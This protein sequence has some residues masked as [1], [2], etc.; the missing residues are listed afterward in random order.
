MS[1]DYLF[2][3]IPMYVEMFY[4]NSIKHLLHF[5]EQFGQLEVCLPCSRLLTGIPILA[6]FWYSFWNSSLH[7]CINSV[8]CQHIVSIKKTLKISKCRSSKQTLTF[9]A[10]YN[11]TNLLI[12]ILWMYKSQFCEI[13]DQVQE[14]HII[15]PTFRVIYVVKL[16]Q[17][18]QKFSNIHSNFLH[19]ICIKFYSLDTLKSKYYLKNLLSGLFHV[20]RNS[21]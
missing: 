14:M 12:S 17:Q 15:I 1:R 10:F 6:V 7:V 18:N 13:F 21:W 5:I 19:K 11:N 4:L 16:F 2:S 20:L 9:A 8:H 3:L